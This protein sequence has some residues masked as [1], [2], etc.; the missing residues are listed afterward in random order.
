MKEM[1]SVV[2]MNHVDVNPSANV[3]KVR[4]TFCTC[5]TFFGVNFFQ[6]YD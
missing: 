1:V 3:A 6:T 2:K 4:P 5:L